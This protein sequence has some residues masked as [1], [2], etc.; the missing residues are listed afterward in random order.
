M[1]G[2]YITLIS[3]V[4]PDLTDLNKRKSASRVIHR[5]YLQLSLY[6][7]IQQLVLP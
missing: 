2:A 1:A 4:V 7:Q 3:S 5:V 6:I